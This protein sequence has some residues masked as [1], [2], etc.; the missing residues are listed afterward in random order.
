MYIMYIHT[1]CQN[2]VKVFWSK[3]FVYDIDALIYCIMGIGMDVET[4]IKM[5]I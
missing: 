3:N 5:N 4:E 2:R 1:V